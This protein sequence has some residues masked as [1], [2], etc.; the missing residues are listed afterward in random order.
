VGIPFDL[1]SCC[2]SRRPCSIDP[3]PASHAEALDVEFLLTSQGSRI[4]NVEKS[5]IV[6]SFSVRAQGSTSR[7]DRSFLLR[8]FCC[9]RKRKA[10]YTDLFSFRSPLRS[11][12]WTIEPHRHQCHDHTTPWRRSTINFRNHI[13]DVEA[14]RANHCRAPC[15]LHQ[16][17]DWVN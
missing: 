3:F 2:E 13:H 5:S 16:I 4:V 14:S 1:A 9:Y 10:L 7:I 15:C 11:I 6:Y 12:I 17:P 8:F